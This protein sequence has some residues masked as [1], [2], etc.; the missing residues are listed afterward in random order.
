MQEGVV[1]DIQ[2]IAECLRSRHGPISAMVATERVLAVFKTP[3]P[4]N[5]HISQQLK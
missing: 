4:E 3:S 5:T 1:P 2:A